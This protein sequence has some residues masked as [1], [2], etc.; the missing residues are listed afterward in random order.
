VANLV[1]DWDEQEASR[2]ERIALVHS[3][4]TQKSGQLADRSFAPAP[5]ETRE[6]AFAPRSS[7]DSSSR[8]SRARAAAARAPLVVTARRRV[9]SP[10]PAQVRDEVGGG[11]SGKKGFAP[12]ISTM[13]G[14]CPRRAWIAAMGCYPAGRYTRNSSGSVFSA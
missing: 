14:Q 9:G 10:V 2:G 1:A 6:R 13:R 8:L 11:S 3:R 7:R 4:A 5:D 12:L